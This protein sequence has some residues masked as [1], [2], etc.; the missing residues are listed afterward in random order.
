MAAVGDVPI[1]EP[2][3]DMLATRAKYPPPCGPTGPPSHK[4]PCCHMRDLAIVCLEKNGSQTSLVKSCFL[5]QVPLRTH[6]RLVQPLRADL[7]FQV[8]NSCLS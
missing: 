1:V 3:Q 4:V 2:Q 8:C 7:D 6:Q 5:Q